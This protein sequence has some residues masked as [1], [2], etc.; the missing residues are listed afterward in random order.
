ME[1]TKNK[2]IYKFFA[3]F[4][5]DEDNQ[6]EVNF[7]DIKNCFTCGSTLDEAIYNAKDVLGLIL[8][9]MEEEN[10]AIPEA[11]EPQNIKL[12]DNEFLMLVDVYMPLV[13][14]SINTKAVKKTLTIPYWLNKLASE[15]SINFSQVLQTA[16]KQ[17]LKIR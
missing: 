10:I 13:R 12:Q 5:K 3:V 9:D 4:K 16:L 8:F 7:P 11:T 1:D 17:E 14:E 15:K 6:Y 2:D